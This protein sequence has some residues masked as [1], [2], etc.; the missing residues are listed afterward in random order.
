VDPVPADASHPSARD[1]SAYLD[2][3]LPHGD[4]DR[5]EAHL[6]DCNECRQEVV[7]LSRLLRSRP[8]RRSMAGW[9][10]A[11]GIAAA[12]VIMVGRLPEGPGT[13]PIQAPGAVERGLVSE[14]EARLSAWGPMGRTSISR[15]SLVLA[16]APSRD[17]NPQ[18]HV[19]LADSEGGILWTGSTRDTMLRLPPS[20]TLPGGRTYYWYTDALLPDGRALSTGVQEFRMAP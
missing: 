12:F 11:A 19:T 4:R 6:A 8:A 17:S 20:L 5:V 14:E 18:Y 13:R 15:D 7:E 2:R 9:A 16:W 1:V 3:A 10:I